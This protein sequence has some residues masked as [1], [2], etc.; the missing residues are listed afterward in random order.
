MKLPPVFQRQYNKAKSLL[1][2]GDPETAKSVV[3]EWIHIS[4]ETAEYLLLLGVANYQLGHFKDAEEQ[5]LK[6]TESNHEVYKAYFYLG[7]CR[8]MQKDNVKAVICFKEACRLKP[9]FEP[10]REKLREHNIFSY[11][12]EPAK[13]TFNFS[14]GLKD[15]IKEIRSKFTNF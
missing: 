13:Q 7:L 15:M 3:E 10:A 11:Q 8:E 12:M 14:G 6:V 5:L 4:G 2:N 1:R 9:E